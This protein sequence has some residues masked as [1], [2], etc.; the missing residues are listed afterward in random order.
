LLPHADK[1][2]SQTLSTQISV[3]ENDQNAQTSI[4]VLRNQEYI[5]IYQT[6]SQLYILA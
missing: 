3:L 1:S 6:V 2:I 5:L 4:S